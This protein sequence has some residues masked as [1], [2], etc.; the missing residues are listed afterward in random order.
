M[1]SPRK[2]TTR[3]KVVKKTIAVIREEFQNDFDLIKFQ[4]SSMN[5]MDTCGTYEICKNCDKNLDYP[6]AM[7]DEKMQPNTH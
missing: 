4:D 1:A 5:Q 2:K 7:A 6:C 3:P